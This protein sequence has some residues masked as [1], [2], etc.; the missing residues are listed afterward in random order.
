MREIAA[1]DPANVIFIDLQPAFEAI[2]IPTADPLDVIGSDS[3]H[4][5]DAGHGLLADLTRRF[6]GIAVTRA[7]A[8]GAGAASRGVTIDTYSRADGNLPV[9]QLKPAERRG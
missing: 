3:I 2:G 4:P 1:A 7:T 9:P 6:L 8:S 5:T